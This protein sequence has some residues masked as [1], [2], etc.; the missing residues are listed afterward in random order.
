[1]VEVGL[2]YVIIYNRRS[3]KMDDVTVN[4]KRKKVK[5]IFLVGIVA[6]ILV[7]LF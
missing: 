4:N 1:M 7:C 3:D 6:I 5:K 2:F